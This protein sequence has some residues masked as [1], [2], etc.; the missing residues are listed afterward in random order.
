MPGLR[1]AGA[2]G[3]FVFDWLEHPDQDAYWQRWS[4]EPRYAQLQVPA[5]HLGGWYDIF[6]RG[7]LRNFV[8]LSAAANAAQQLV[9]GPWMHMPWSRSV[10]CLDFG[11]EADSQVDQRQLAFFDRHLKEEEAGD[12]A[13]K[14]SV[15]VMG[16][17]RWRHFEAWPPAGAQARTFYLHSGGLANTAA[18]D[19]TLSADAP[20]QEPPDVF[21]Y[22]PLAPV[23]SAG[24][25]SCCFAGAAPMGP[26]WQAQVELAPGVLVY[27]GAVFEKSCT[28]IGPVSVRLWAVST[29][30]DTDFTAKLC[31]VQADG[32]SVNLCGGILR[33]RYRESLVEPS[34]IEPGRAYLY[35]I[36]LGATAVTCAPG[37]RLRLQ[38]SSSDFP[39]W[40]RNLNTGGV[41]GAEGPSAAVVAT[42]LVLHE[43][44]YPS[45]LELLVCEE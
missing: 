39:Q 24:G 7:T 32:T 18:G 10:G 43:R 22:S 42:Q 44:A 23:A 15:F 26:A 31:L 4:L 30:R 8:G 36:D 20:E 34:L 13:R 1:R 16:E 25:A 5:L 29:A 41:F 9:V 11:S 6:L 38:V 19:G 3:Q 12:F 14:V 17:N 21:V 45:A 27:T 35:R 40:D 2:E 37:T 33:A 28:I